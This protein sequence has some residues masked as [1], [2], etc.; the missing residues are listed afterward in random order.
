MLWK[1]CDMY[2]IVLKAIKKLTIKVRFLSIMEQV[3]GI[4]PSS[5]PWQG[6]ILAAVLH[7]R[8]IDK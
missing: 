1:N 7:L 3:N 8:D 6:R 4:E 5:Q 2:C